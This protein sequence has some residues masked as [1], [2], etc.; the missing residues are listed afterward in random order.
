MWVG[1]EGLWVGIEGLWVSRARL[2]V[3]A[4]RVHGHER[5][6]ERVERV[7]MRVVRS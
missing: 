5:T 4:L 7:S 2:K 6:H 3:W 1:I